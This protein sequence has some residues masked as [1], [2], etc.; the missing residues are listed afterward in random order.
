MYGLFGF[1]EKL[2]IQS[3]VNPTGSCVQEMY[4]L[5]GFA[6]RLNF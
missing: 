6:E 5:S 4:G 3:Y 1:A 2:N